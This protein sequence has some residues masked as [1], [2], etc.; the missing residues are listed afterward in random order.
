MGLTPRDLLDH[1][2]A[3]NRGQKLY[4]PGHVEATKYNPD[5]RST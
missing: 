1:L 3:E 5:Q 4:K 2:D